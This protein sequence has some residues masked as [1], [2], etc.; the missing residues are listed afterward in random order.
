MRPLK[1]AASR[2]SSLFVRFRFMCSG[3]YVRGDGFHVRG[4]V[5]HFGGHRIAQEARS[6]WRPTLDTLGFHARGHPRASRVSTHR[7]VA[8]ARFHDRPRRLRFPRSG[9][10]CSGWCW[11]PRSGFL[12]SG[13]GGRWC[14]RLASV[15]V[16]AAARW[17]ERGGRCCGPLVRAW[18]SMVRPRG[19]SVVVDGA[20]PWRERGGRWSGPVVRAWWSMVRP[21]G[22][23]VVVDGAA[24]WCE[25]GGRWCGPVARAWWS[26]VRPAGAVRNCKR[27]A[28]PRE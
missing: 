16:D 9:F 15:V 18:W 11:F 13:C 3:S 26:M 6:A 24:R 28:H 8:A 14:E 12:R 1:S 10:P 2:S 22:A 27:P 4:T 5:C 19:A 7:A 23:S 17:C 25:R 20:A 21:A